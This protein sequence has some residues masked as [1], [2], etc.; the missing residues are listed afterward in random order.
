MQEISSN[1]FIPPYPLKTAVLFM[2]FN[3]PDTTKQVF[4]AIRKAEPPRFYVAA[5]G[6]RADKA[7][8]REKCERG[9]R[10][11]TQVDWDCEVRALFREKNLGCRAG[12]SSAI[13]WFFENEE[14]GIILEDDCL[15]SLSFLWFCEELLER[16]R[17]DM[18]V[19]HISGITPGYMMCVDSVNWLYLVSTKSN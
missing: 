19:W 16:Y 12:V 17:G 4:E 7:G 5:D 10:I 6:P 11:T 13:D 2:T 15:P 8:E 3:R 1:T 9:R 14:E 18:R